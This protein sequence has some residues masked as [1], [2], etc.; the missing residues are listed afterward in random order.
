MARLHVCVSFSLE[1][2]LVHRRLQQ[3]QDE[4]HKALLEKIVFVLEKNYFKSKL[5]NYYY[6]EEGKD[7]E[8]DT[9]RRF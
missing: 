9:V 8:K 1:I 2:R 6:S 3:V 4:L 5:A 7:E